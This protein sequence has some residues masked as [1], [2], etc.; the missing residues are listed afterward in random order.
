MTYRVDNRVQWKT[1]FWI[2]Y[3]LYGWMLHGQMAMEQ[4]CEQKQTKYHKF[5]FRGKSGKQYACKPKILA[6]LY[7]KIA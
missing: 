3:Y 7:L 5:M 1:T 6:G 4:Y 2:H